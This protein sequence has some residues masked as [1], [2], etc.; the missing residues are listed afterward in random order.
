MLQAGAWQAV[1]TRVKAGNE[2]LSLSHQDRV[3]DH[4]ALCPPSHNAESGVSSWHRLY[5]PPECW[6]SPKT[7]KEGDPSETTGGGSSSQHKPSV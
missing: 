3:G 7:L 4:K 6:V 5:T 2:F 1:N